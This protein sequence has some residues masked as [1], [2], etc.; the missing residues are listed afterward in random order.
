MLCSVEAAL[1]Q[2]PRHGYHA[3]ILHRH[4]EP[5]LGPIR[6]YRWLFLSLPLR[7]ITLFV[8]SRSLLDDLHIRLMRKGGTGKVAWA[9]DVKRPTALS[10]R[11]SGELEDQQAC[12]RLADETSDC[13]R[14]ALIRSKGGTF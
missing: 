8:D 9:G 13:E 1:S 10:I 14:L 3:S 2:L 4:C 11:G 12:R 7:W 6:Q 5:E